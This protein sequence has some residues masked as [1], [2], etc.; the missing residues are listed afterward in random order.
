MTSCVQLSMKEIRK[1]PA[2]SGKTAIICNT[3]TEACTSPMW[4]THALA[5]LSLWSCGWHRTEMK[6]ALP[7]GR[8]AA[9]RAAHFSILHVRIKF[10]LPRHGKVRNEMQRF[11]RPPSYN[12]CKDLN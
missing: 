1:A 6:K 12:Y 2:L 11:E 10:H 5:F 9:R 3:T 7:F 8:I 4:R